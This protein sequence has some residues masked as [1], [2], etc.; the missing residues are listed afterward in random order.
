M[1]D[2][3]LGAGV[4][5]GRGRLR[6]RGRRRAAPGVPAAGGAV[7]A[8][9]GRAPPGGVGPTPGGPAPPAPALPRRG[10]AGGPGAPPP[11]R[12]PARAAAEAVTPPHVTTHARVVMETL[13]AVVAAAIIITIRYSH[14][15]KGRKKFYDFSV[16]VIFQV[17]QVEWKP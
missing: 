12:R 5:C 8:R 17:V 11:P 2:T 3:H 13:P 9:G 7:P 16:L 15:S 4:V 6:S 1:P 14:Q 10:P